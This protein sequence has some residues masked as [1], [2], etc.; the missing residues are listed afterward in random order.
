M[1]ASFLTITPVL[2]GAMVVLVLLATAIAAA[3][4]L[5]LGPRFALAAARGTVQLAVVAVVIT[6]VVRSLWLTLLF[7]LVMAVVAAVTS[8]RR[9]G[10]GVHW[11]LLPVTAGTMPLV[12]GALAAGIVP[13][14]GL[15]IVPVTGILLGGA[16]TAT[17]LAGRRAVDEMRGRRGEIEAALALGLDDRSAVLEIIRPSAAQALS[18]AL[19]Q[20]RTVGL[21]TLPGAFVGM[22][23]AGASPPAAAAVQLFVLVSLLAVEALA[24]V[25]TVELA[26]RGRIGRAATMT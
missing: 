25:L 1:G 2:G 5:G 6:A 7:V 18:P 17:S 9:V 11:M 15:A 21:V 10:G 24:V 23:L 16:M 14:R 4:R 3:G 22:L 19:D 26:A 12:S 20:T 13:A 8:A